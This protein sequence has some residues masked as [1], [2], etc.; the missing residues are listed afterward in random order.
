M[1]TTNFII[2]FSVVFTVFALINFYVFIRGW[3]ALPQGNTVRKIYFVLFLIAFFSFMGGRILERYY[4]SAFTD[5]LIWIGSFWFAAIMY[6][7]FIVIFLDILRTINTSTPLYPSFATFNY[8]LTKQIVFA[9]SV[10][11]VG[12]VLAYGYYNAKNPKIQKLELNI[13]KNCGELK[14][15][16]IVMISDMHL[17]TIISNSRLT[18][19]IDKTNS[20]NPDIILLAGD[21]VDEDLG[22]VIRN[23]IGETFKN[24]KSKYGTYGITGN[25][26]YIGGVEE[27]CTYLNAH[28]ITMLRD[29]AVKIENAFYIIGR[30]DRDVIRFAGK[31]RK[32]LE[33]LVKQT[34]KNCPL[35][36]MNHQPFD[37]DESVKNDIDLQLSGHTH[38]GQLFP[39]NFITSM[40][41]ELSTGYL[42]KGQTHFYVSTGAGTWGPPVRIG[43]T[44]EIVNIKLKF[45]N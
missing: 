39:L 9:L 27:A 34:D 2:F 7:L 38:H 24:F 4:Y 28:N 3:Q 12:G 23:N 19:M 21:I 29:S 22:P 25:H 30:E 33:E 8:P 40:V 16:N 32:S 6:F 15:L 1:K 36:L 5:I 45:G 37:L 17:G 35:I 26:E 20:L 10:V 14:E 43:N 31:K 18:D 41:F 13:Y 44:P 42:K 11:I